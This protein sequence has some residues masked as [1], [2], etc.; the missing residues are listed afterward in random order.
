MKS[1][2]TST[3]FSKHFANPVRRTCPSTRP[4]AILSPTLIRSSRSVGPTVPCRAFTAIPDK[5][6]NVTTSS[7]AYIVSK[8]SSAVK[9]QKVGT[10]RVAAPFSSLLVS[11]QQQHP[12][13]WRRQRYYSA[14]RAL[15]DADKGG[16]KSSSSSASPLDSLQTEAGKWWNAGI[17]WTS[18]IASSSTSVVEETAQRATEAAKTAASKTLTETQRLAEQATGQVTS[19]AKDSIQR[20]AKG[21]EEGV[22]K[23]TV[24]VASDLGRSTAETLS[25]TAEALGKAATTL[26]QS[27]GETL[28]RTTQTVGAVSHEAFTRTQESAKEGVGNAIETTIHRPI[29]AASESIQE[30]SQQLVEGITSSGTK[31][32]RWVWWWSLAAVAVYAVATTLP[33]ALIKYAME[34][35]QQETSAPPSSTRNGGSSGGGDGGGTRP[36]RQVS[37]GTTAATSSLGSA[38]WN[39]LSGRQADTDGALNPSSHDQDSPRRWWA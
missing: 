20:G 5:S 17:G 29:R 32:L 9:L 33:M 35:P 10:S 19:V 24:A 27:A 6:R 23:P 28:A 22:W 21:L 36:D 25:Q 12:P 16:N 11:G 7:T 3:R 38:V 30:T 37:A 8:I 31:L 15:L 18:Q 14:T 4:D 34:K 26:G 39:W 13:L 2:M 1:R